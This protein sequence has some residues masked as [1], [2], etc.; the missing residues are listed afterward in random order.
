MPPP[1]PVTVIGYVPAVVVNPTVMVIVELPVPG[2]PMVLGLKIT[3]VP[4]GTPEADKLIE[5]LKPPPTVLVIV[6][7]P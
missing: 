6:A 3:V 7:V 2:A 5:L 4:E 1:F